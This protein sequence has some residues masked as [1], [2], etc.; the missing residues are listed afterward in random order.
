MCVRTKIILNCTGPYRYYGESVV[1]SCVEND[2]HYL[3][4]AGESEFIERA[5]L[6]YN[7]EAKVNKVLVINACGFDSIPSDLGTVFTT[8]QYAKNGG[9]ASHIEAFIEIFNSPGGHYATYECLAQGLSHQ[10]EL[11]K[12]HN[13]FLKVNIPYIGPKLKRKFIGWDERIGKCHILFPGADLSI[14]RNSQRQLALN[15]GLSALSNIAPAQFG[16]CLT[17]NTLFQ[18]IGYVLF[19]IILSMLCKLSFGKKY[20]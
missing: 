4:I 8:S 6:E 5:M 3:D 13:L 12:L 18:L 9:V 19:G 20:Y 14:A 11:R 15:N 7:E 10:E 1:R 17:A 16:M 2:S